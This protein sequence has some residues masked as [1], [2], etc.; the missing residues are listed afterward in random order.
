M[1]EPSIRDL[2]DCQ[3]QVDLQ[4]SLPNPLGPGV[5][6]VCRP[7]EAIVTQYLEF[8]FPYFATHGPVYIDLTTGLAT[9]HL[10]TAVSAKGHAVCAGREVRDS[11][12]GGLHTL[13]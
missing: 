3:G 13:A 4:L 5:H 7:Q 1:D 8:T 10:S 9:C 11:A 6:R 12:A 2:E